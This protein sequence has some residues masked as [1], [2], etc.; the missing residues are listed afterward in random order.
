MRGCRIGR[1]HADELIAAASVRLMARKAIARNPA[2]LLVTTAMHEYFEERRRGNRQVDH[3]YLSAQD[4]R[5]DGGFSQSDF[6]GDPADRVAREDA[7]RTENSIL[8][9]SLCTLSD[10]DRSLLTERYYEEKPLDDMARDRGLSVEATTSRLWRA[11][12]RLRREYRR[13]QTRG[14]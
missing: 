4:G 10:E 2:A 9:R 13:E 14:S 7:N 12:V 8:H 1:E 3:V 5:V 6:G 11:R